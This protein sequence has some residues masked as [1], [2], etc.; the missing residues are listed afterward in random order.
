MKRKFLF[1]LISAVCS[2]LATAGEPVKDTTI[3]GQLNDY[4]SKRPIEK[5]YLHQDR[6]CYRAGETV[7]L[8]LYQVLSASARNASKVAY[9]DLINEK[10]E[11][12]VQAKYPL[13]EG[14][15]TGSLDIPSDISAGA[16][17]LRAYTQWMCNEGTDS[18]FRREVKIQGQTGKEV[19]Q[20]ASESGIRLQFFPEGGNLI[21]GLAS[22]V[23]LESVAGLTGKGIP[24][25]GTILNAAKEVIQHFQTN[26]DGKGSFFFQPQPQPQQQYFAQ[27]EGDT[28]QFDIPEILPSGFVLNVKRFKKVLRIL[29]TQNIEKEKLRQRYTLVFHQSGQVLI[30]VPVDAVNPRSVLDIP[31]DKLPAGIFTVT[32]IDENYR[33]YCERAVFIRFP[34]TLD[35]RLASNVTQY[36]EHPMMTID[37]ETCDKT[38]KPCSANLSLAVA[39][40]S[41]ENSRVRTNFKTYLF[42]ESELKG[43]VKLPQSYWKPDAPESLS[44]IELLL[45]TQGWCRYSL[46]D[47]RRE[48]KEPAYVME[49]GLSLG[50]KVEIGTQKARAITVQAVLR[51]DSMQQLTTCLLDE[52]GHFALT[53]FSFEGIKEVMFSATDTRKQSFPIVMDKPHSL[54][55]AAYAPFICFASAY[56]SDSLL[57]YPI[58]QGTIRLDEVKVTARKKDKLAKRRSYGEGFVKSGFDVG[59]N[60]YGDMR[61]LLSRVPGLTSV[62][63]PD[64]RKA[65]QP[66]F[67][68]NG[69]PNG[70]TATFVL[71]DFVVRDPEMIYSMD[72]SLIERIE[73]LQSTATLFGGFSSNG[74]IVVIYTRE[75]GNATVSNKEICQWIGYNQ[76]KEFYTPT[77]PDTQFF[78]NSQPRNTFYWNPNITTDETGKARIAFYL[79]KQEVGIPSVVH[80]E[81]YSSGG[82]IGAGAHYPSLK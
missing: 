13:S 48:I 15:A 69:T 64:K 59:E 68:V 74:G 8:K 55:S 36:D 76:T 45:L 28:R 72:A 7:W 4:I 47:L 53:D 25:K 3:V 70:T 82:L 63:N 14:Q 46:A 41:A 51:Q 73:V 31:V 16:Y 60:N 9:V 32:L 40:A 54:L 56:A 81:G 66:Y 1:L 61:R 33:A 23:A 79:K 50:G 27:I 43:T 37:I 5:L 2:I 34:E 17:Q 62:S 12:L 75:V 26:A 57:S 21:E 20:A 44:K 78:G 29:L 18:F 11:T 39:T 6:S 49:Q 19:A 42:L 35:I 24:V 80:C 71:N 52:K 22:K 30:Q 65:S 58:D 67:Q 10:G 38:G 77:L